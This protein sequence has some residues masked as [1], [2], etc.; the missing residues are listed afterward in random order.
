[1]IVAGAIAGAVVYYWLWPKVIARLIMRR[2]EA[3]NRAAESNNNG[4]KES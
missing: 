3:Y 4:G 2:V 1:M